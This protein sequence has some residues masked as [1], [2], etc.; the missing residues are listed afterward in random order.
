MTHRETLLSVEEIWRR[1]DDVET[2]LTTPLSER[3]LDL[4]GLEPGMR[5]LDLATGRGEPAL[6][7]ARRVGPHGSVVGVELSD[8]LLQMAREK[9]AAA[10]LRNLELRSANAE[11]LENIPQNNFH[12]VT[13]RWALMYMA[14]PIAA[15]LNARR[16]L[17]PS[18]ILVA[19]FWAEPERVPYFT[20]PRRRLLRYRPLPVFD[21][22]APGPFRYANVDRIARDLSRAGFHVEHVEEMEIPVF[23]A[24]SSAEVVAWVRAFG[25]ARLLEDLPKG[26][27]LA[28]QQE[29]TT[30]LELNRKDGLISLGGVTR[31]VR[32]RRRDRRANQPSW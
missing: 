27:Q 23:A 26:Q 28:W 6:R 15:M 8:S 11:L 30:E 25:L 10:G 16:A 1:Y 18:G 21:P 31:I 9:A 22:E 32:A 20:L 24:P 13:A 3:M 5:V 17:L 14:A 7:A 2:R 12:A 4:A 19:A 29:L